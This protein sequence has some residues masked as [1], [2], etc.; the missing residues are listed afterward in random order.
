MTERIETEHLILRKARESD[1][2]AIWQNV[3][4]DERLA[5]TML[6]KPT[7]LQE[8]AENRMRRTLAYQAR[9]DAF[10]VCTREGDEPIGFAGIRETEPGVFEETGICIGAE[11]QGRGWGREV[12]CA[13]VDLAFRE[14][15][16]KRFLYGCFRENTRSAA[17]CR[18]C[19]FVYSHSETLTRE[20]DGY[21][22]LCDFYVLIS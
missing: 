16:G 5:R 6:W 17:L 11:W 7:A 20:W 9:S 13:L 14:R 10:F 19:G 3:W 2:P 15:G 1:L 21:A 4:R 18:S 12:L 8:E 22:Y